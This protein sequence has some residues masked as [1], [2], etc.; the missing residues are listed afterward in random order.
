[1][2]NAGTMMDTALVE[3]DVKRPPMREGEVSG[4]DP[5]AGFIRY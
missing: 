4:R 3:A 5:I 2:I 1:V